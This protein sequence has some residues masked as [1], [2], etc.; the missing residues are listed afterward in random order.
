MSNLKAQ[1]LAR[2]LLGLLVV[3][4]VASLFAPGVVLL[5]LQATVAVA[6]E[7][8]PLRVVTDD[9]YPPYLFRGDDGAPTGYLVDYWKLWQAK[10]GVPVTL[11][12]KQ[13]SEAQQQVLAG[14]ADVID[15]LYKTPGREPLYDFT[16]PYA[17]LP[18][19]IYHDK[20]IAGITAVE[21][22]KGFRIGVQAG[23]AC[24]ERLVQHGITAHAVYPNYAALIAAAQR[25][26]FRI[27]CLDEYPANFYLEKQG[28]Q[29]DFRKA[30]TLY[31]GQFRRGIPKGHAQTLALVQRGMAAITE[32]ERQALA[33]KWF[34]Q[35]LHPRF[36]LDR[37]Q[38]LLGLAVL[39]ACSAM[40][41]AA[42]LLLR[43]QVAARTRDLRLANASLTDQ[44]ETLQ[45][46]ARQLSASLQEVQQA[47]NA[48]R[49]SEQAL[50]H[51]RLHLEELVRE[52][53]HQLAAE[54]QRMAEILENTHTATWEWNVQ[55]GETTFDAQW[56]ALVGYQLSELAP[57]SFGL[58]QRLAHPDDLA[59]SGE[60]LAQHFSGALPVYEVEARMKH[61]AGHWVWVLDRG[62]VSTWTGDGRP[63][64]MRG[65]HQDISA[66]K[67]AELALQQAKDAAEAA[68]LAKSS[69]L[70]NMSHEIRTPLNGVLG[71]A[72]I[73]HR[74]SLGRSR[75]EQTFARIIDSGKL[76]L[77][78]VNDILDFSK[79]EA[80]K[81]DVESL[82]L[83]PDQVVDEVVQGMAALAAAKQLGLVLDRASLP[84]AVLGDPVRLAQILYNLLSNAIKFTEQ[85]E[86]R[87]SAGVDGSLP[88]G[89]LVFAVQD[90]GIGISDDVLGRLF[91][92]FQQADGSFTRRYGGTGLGLAISRSLAELMGGSLSVASVPGQGSCFTL[93]LPLRTTDQPVAGGWNG[94]VSGVQRL[95]GLHLLVAEDNAVNQLVLDEMLR[96]EGA[97]IVVVADG[98]QALACA[99]STLRPF[100]AV[101][102]DV[103]MPVMDG[104][105]ATRA[106]ALSH[107]TLP[108]IGQ[109]AH[110]LQ[111]ET[112]RCL[113]AGMV[114]TLQKPID[115]E[116]LVSTLLAHTRRIRRGGS[117]LAPLLA[118]AE[119]R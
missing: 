63:L 25:R 97:D 75:A 95:A 103:Q 105:A 26:E 14:D 5:G 114:A 24:V 83:H 37:E 41:V 82:P 116:V 64:L 92:P 67:S 7:P 87:L 74:D 77:T 19:N 54:R 58:W 12:A 43:R 113:L 39:A 50:Q 48:L 90:T 101:L 78:I 81:L 96:G 36:P 21:S 110:A 16:E 112:D 44:R 84:A 46:N 47:E 111:E 100:D 66:R 2:S 51:H 118:T 115:L 55:T 28:L 68:A 91:Q 106:L 80:G 22:L 60:L 109:T 20:I 23:D 117:D 119:T 13:W 59:R 52:R 38:V 61:K 18:V 33:D 85:G 53:T 11:T 65:T 93:R 45:R 56:A 69:F 107:P 1:G 10:T 70:A 73:G 57:E 29:D 62:T 30:F 3:P 42:L 72:Q 88:G 40:A 31:T 17:D 34:G 49:A 94:T 99:A 27:F 104:L 86:V 8:T 76:L 108:V 35:A 15:M 9:N 71:L 79:I 4:M 6:A 32:A 102:M 98:Q 89:A